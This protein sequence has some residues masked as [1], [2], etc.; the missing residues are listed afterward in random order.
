MRNLI[1]NLLPKAIPIRAVFASG[2]RLGSPCLRAARGISLW[3]LLL[4]TVLLGT[5]PAQAE[6]WADR[7]GSGFA[8][9]GYGRVFTNDILGDGDDRWRTGAYVLSNLRGPRGTLSLPDRIGVLYELRFG[10]Q[11]I[12]PANLTEGGA[13]D[14]PYAGVISAGLH[15]YFQ[16]GR[17]ELR[18]GLDLVAT[19]PSTGV[20]NFHQWFHERFDMVPPSD[21]VQQAQIGNRIFPT[22]SFEIARPLRFGAATLRP[23]LSAQAGVESYARIGGDLLFG[24]A[25][26]NPVLLRDVTTGQLYPGLQQASDP[27]WSFL[28]GADLAHVF[29]SALLPQDRG[30]ELTNLRARA[31]AGVQRQG[32]R[33]GMFYGLTWLGREFDSQPEGQL[34][35]SVSLRMAF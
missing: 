6:G 5:V 22:A 28:I 30:L 34:V 3:F 19:G 18:A 26:R 14:R 8:S 15:S 35:G 16:R 13:G 32:R 9:L 29:D 27:G 33:W 1:S 2:R 12:S 21:S 23:F 4:L 20:G 17:A 31:R 10:V 11:M 24:P 7:D 25:Y